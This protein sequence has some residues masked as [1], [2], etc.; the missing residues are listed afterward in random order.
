MDAKDEKQ[1]DTTSGV[2]RRRVLVGGSAA[3]A[4]AL[5]VPKRLW[6][7][8][9]KPVSI[10]FWT[11]ENPQQRPWIHKR[12]KMYMEKN[13]HVKV[14]FQFFPFGDLGKKL[15]VGFATGTAP[16]G[17]ASQDW[18]M[19]VWLDKGLLAPLKPEMVGFKSV[20]EFKQMHTDAAG[21]TAT[22]GDKLYGVPFQFYGFCNYL[23]TRHFKEVG[24][25][26]VKDWPKSWPELGEVAK[27]LSIK[28]GN[29]FV[30]QGFKFAMHSPVWTT[31]QFNPILHQ[32]G[33]QWFDAQGKCVINNEA[34]VK[35]M[36]V[37]ASMARQYDAEDPAD[38]IATNPLPMMDWLRERASMFFNHPIPLVAIESQNPKM[39]AERYFMPVQY[40]GTTPSKR[41]ST[42]Y[43][44]HF[45]VS[46][47]TTPEKAQVL[48]DMYRFIMED[49]TD[50]WKDVAPFPAA[51]KG[52]W[53]EDP[54][55]KSYPGFDQI[56]IARDNGVPLPRTLVFNELADALHRTV[57]NVV[58]NR[59]DIKASLDS[60]AAEIDRALTGYK[61]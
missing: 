43:G 36:T 47:K 8:P 37:R 17:F 53:M 34:G 50:L 38:T 23:N 15:A 13:P 14:D 20:A 54:A 46:S 27:R 35:A 24:L 2:T 33:G 26:A 9:K 6:G 58:L 10:S 31:I 40:P 55:V 60:A 12:V 51:R 30:R 59:G 16:D 7:Q 21:Q 42:T 28:E 4:T 44:F 29:R 32:H 57:Q 22:S 56:I 3:A 11:W 52:A 39:A 25:N 49:L 1:L 18:V 45:V 48:Q 5:V 41:Y 19:P 61:R